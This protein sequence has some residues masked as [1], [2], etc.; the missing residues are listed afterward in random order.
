MMGDNM[1][2]ISED[3]SVSAALDKY[4]DTARRQGRAIAL[5]ALRLAV[6]DLPATTT[7]ADVLDV[8]DRM[9]ADLAAET[10]K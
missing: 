3:A 9:I 1:F 5:S 2:K 7:T 10:P 8:L 6:L 4:A